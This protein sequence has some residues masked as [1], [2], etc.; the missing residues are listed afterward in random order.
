MA[1]PSSNTSL[2]S[3]H[4]ASASSPGE[5]NTSR[6][7]GHTQHLQPPHAPGIQHTASQSPPP[8]YVHLPP[9][10]S[11]GPNS[12][13]DSHGF[14][15]PYPQG[16]PSHGIPVPYTPPI[17]NP[18]FHPYFSHQHQ[19]FGPT[20]LS[21]TVPLLHAHYEPP[22]AAD[23]RARKRFVRSVMAAFGVCLLA[24]VIIGLEILGEI[25]WG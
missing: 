2:Q 4:E 14:Y 25:A 12:N 17:P 22:G 7:G 5:V 20:P 18:L 23:N 24:S 19:H 11:G 6:S 10:N 3:S 1:Q 15:G 21:A 16:Y 8:P 13:S 9:V